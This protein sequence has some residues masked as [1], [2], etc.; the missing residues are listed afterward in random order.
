MVLCI[1]HPQRPYYKGIMYMYIFL[2]V[3][4]CDAPDSVQNG[5]ASWKE[6]YVGSI[7]LYSCDIGYRLVGST[8]RICKSTTTWSPS[9]P[10]C[11]KWIHTHTASF[12]P[13]QF[14]SFSLEILV[15][16]PSIYFQEAEH[17][18]TIENIILP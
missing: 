7:A 5:N 16:P 10:Y 1:Q 4:S 2:P 3:L 11:S 18:Q 9:A 13:C 17:Y 14:L 6:T 8:T 12:F 15:F